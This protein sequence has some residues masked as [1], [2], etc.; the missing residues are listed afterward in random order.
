MAGSPNRDPWVCIAM[1]GQR[2]CAV[3]R[4]DSNLDLF[5]FKGRSPSRSASC[6]PGVETI[7]PAVMGGAVLLGQDAD[8]LLRS[9]LTRS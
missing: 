2:R 6:R 1:P 3:S 4:P 8:I 9:V 5:A 7:Y